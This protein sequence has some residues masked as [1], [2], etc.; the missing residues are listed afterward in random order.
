MERPDARHRGV[1][2]S[3]GRRRDRRLQRACD[4]VVR[5]SAAA[6]GLCPTLSTLGGALVGVLVAA[7]VAVAVGDGDDDGW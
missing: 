1:R 7:T 4:A 3:V 5:L 2:V 6:A